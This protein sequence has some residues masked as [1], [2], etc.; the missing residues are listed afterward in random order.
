[1]R[2]IQITW[3]ELGKS[4][5]PSTLREIVQNAMDTKSHL[6][7]VCIFHN[8]CEMRYPVMEKTF[9][10]KHAT[11][12]R[13]RRSRCEREI[14]TPAHTQTHPHTLSRALVIAGTREYCRPEQWMERPAIS[15]RHRLRDDDKER[16]FGYKGYLGRAPGG[17]RT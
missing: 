6:N 16:L 12:W 5:A 8:Q 15:T 17:S 4:L 10:R 7:D 2:R 11:C 13:N 3:D 9:L 14:H 1:M